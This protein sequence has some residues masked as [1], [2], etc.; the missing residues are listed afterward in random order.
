MDGQ[1]FNFIFRACRECNARKGDAERHVSSITL[2]NSPE[3]ETDARANAAAIRK[4]KA[5]FHPDKKGVRVQDAF[6]PMKIGATF[7]AMSMS[8]GLVGPPQL[9]NSAAGEVALSHIQGLYSLIT[10]TD[11]Q[12][13]NRMGLLPMDK[14]IWYDLYTHRDWGN[15]QAMEIARRVTHWECLANIVSAEGYF[16]AVLRC[17]E[18][19]WFWALEWN[20]ELRLVGGLSQKRMRLFENLPSENWVPAPE[21]RMR[22]EIPLDPDA[23]ILFVG[24]V[25]GG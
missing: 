12:D 18:D 20:K 25:Q 13:S 24:E 5:D 22:C 19:E 1:P 2:F 15:P 16:K 9:L 11:Y 21:G 7:G 10:T 14:F 23:D 17:S 6:E 4:G 8:V 3:R